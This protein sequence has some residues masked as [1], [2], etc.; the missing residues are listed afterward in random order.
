MPARAT[1]SLVGTKWK[2]ELLESVL[3]TLIVEDRRAHNDLLQ[4]ED[5]VRK[6]QW[7]LQMTSTMHREQTTLYY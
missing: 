2:I 7:K 6:L 4:T 3:A 1:L 5:M